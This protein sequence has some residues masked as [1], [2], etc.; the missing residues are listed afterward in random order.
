[1][2]DHGAQSLDEATEHPA[3]L[4]GN[5]AGIGACDFGLDVGC[6][7]AEHDM[8]WS[9]RFTPRG[10]V[11]LN[12]SVDQLQAAAQLFPGRAR[13]EVSLL[14]ADAASVS[15][16]CRRMLLASLGARRKLDPE[17]MDYVL[18]R[19]RKPDALAA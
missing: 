17:A 7:F 18:V 16:A 10:I 8:L 1:M 5:A 15:P 4:V 2:L 3:V 9:S 14:A 13:L 6:G 11:G 19:G 12:L